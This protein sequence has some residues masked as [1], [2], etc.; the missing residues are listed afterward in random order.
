[1][2]IST[3]VAQR[4]LSCS[5]GAGFLQQDTLTRA[6]IRVLLVGSAN[7][8]V[9]FLFVLILVPVK[10]ENGHVGSKI[11]SSRYFAGSRRLPFDASG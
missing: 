10:A 7:K 2:K 5:T 1:M 4:R 9:A 8:E 3:A 11:Q 6:P